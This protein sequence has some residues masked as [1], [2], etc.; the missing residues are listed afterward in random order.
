MESLVLGENE[1]YNMTIKNYMEV[2]FKKFNEIPPKYF[3][4]VKQNERH[5]VSGD[6]LI[7]PIASEINN[8]IFNVIK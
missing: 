6:G 2:D 1:K 7:D 3:D 4:T 8:H 5:L